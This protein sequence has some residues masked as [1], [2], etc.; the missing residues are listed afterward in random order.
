M[1][2]VIRFNDLRQCDTFILQFSN[3]NDIYAKIRHE[4]INAL[5]L[6]TLTKVHITKLEECIPVEIVV[7]RK[8]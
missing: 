3:N 4:G 8:D 5:N 2:K 7:K 1:S 6:T